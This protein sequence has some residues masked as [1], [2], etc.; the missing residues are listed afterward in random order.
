MMNHLRLSP[1]LL[2]WNHMLIIPPFSLFH[3]SMHLIASAVLIL[4]GLATCLAGVTSDPSSASGKTFDYIV[5][6]DLHLLLRLCG[7][8]QLQA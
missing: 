5:V 2:E 4:A 8:S 1:A 3:H 7:I 6:R